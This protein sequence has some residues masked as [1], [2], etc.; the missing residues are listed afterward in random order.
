VQGRFLIGAITGL[1]WLCSF[2][3]LSHFS[4]DYQVKC[5]VIDAGHGGVDPGNLGAKSRE[6]DI[7]LQVSLELG[8][9]IKKNLPGVKVIYTRTEDK[10]VELHKRPKIAI[11]N[12]ADVFIS[13][14]CNS[15]PA[16]MPNRNLVKGTETYVMGTHVNDENLEVAK[17]ENSAIFNEE[18]YQTAYK[19][20][21]P[22][23]PETYILLS[24][25]QQV[26]L[27]NSLDLAKKIENQFKYRVKRKSRG[28]KQAGFVV[29]SESTM[30]SVLVELGF[31]SNPE[32]EKFL[33][34]ALG[35]VY[36][37]SAIFRALRDYKNEV[38]GR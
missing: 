22:N 33:K 25:N 9:L 7:T 38:E 12:Q 13:I 1:I 30:P 14:H 17:K 35:Q 18:N 24:L 3:Q 11:Q 19:G 31:L 29:L 36:L 2:G 5:V 20:F 32:E 6:K 16:K 21:N 34:D 10:L 23:A 28:V 8:Q 26:H 27:Q 15:T 37:A 4:A